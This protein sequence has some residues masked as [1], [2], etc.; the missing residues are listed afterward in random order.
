MRVTNESLDPGLGDCATVDAIVLSTDH[1]NPSVSI[2]ISS[3]T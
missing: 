1:G 2:Q 3:S